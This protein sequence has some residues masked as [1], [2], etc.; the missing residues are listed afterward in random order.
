[1]QEKTYEEVQAEKKV[2]AESLLTSKEIKAAAKEKEKKQKKPAKK[3][4][5]EPKAPAPAHQVSFEEKPHV[6]FEL[7]EEIIPEEPAAIPKEK[8]AK[9]KSEKKDKVTT[10]VRS[11]LTGR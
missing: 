4:P 8:E 10:L 7:E 2:F 9:K 5:K 6:E 11:A 3:Q 1:M